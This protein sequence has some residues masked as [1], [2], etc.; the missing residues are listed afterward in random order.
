MPARPIDPI[1]YELQQERAHALGLAAKKMEEAVAALKAW[2]AGD[3]KPGVR[4]EDLFAEA[5]ERVWYYV[6]HRDALGMYDHQWALGVYDVPMEL[7]AR[8]GPRKR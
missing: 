7:Y 2:D 3:R 8:M 4:R 6:I 1:E 5:A